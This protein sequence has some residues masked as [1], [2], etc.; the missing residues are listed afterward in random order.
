MEKID[1]IIK[2]AKQ[3]NNKITIEMLDN[4]NIKE[5]EFSDN[6]INGIGDETNANN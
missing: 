3:N 2:C 5:N 4:F 1:E 6:H